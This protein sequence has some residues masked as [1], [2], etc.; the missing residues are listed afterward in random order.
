MAMSVCSGK[1]TF[2]IHREPPTDHNTNLVGGHI[3]VS[4]KSQDLPVNSDIIL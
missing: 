2:S 1:V 3:L 4:G